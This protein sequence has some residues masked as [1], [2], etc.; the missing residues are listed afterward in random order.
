[1]IDEEVGKLL[2]EAEERGLAILIDHREALDRLT[3]LLLDQETIDGSDVE[4]ILDSSLP[5]SVTG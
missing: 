3:D 4:R 2:R 1:V 5:I